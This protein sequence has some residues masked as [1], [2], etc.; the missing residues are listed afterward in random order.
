MKVCKL[1]SEAMSYVYRKNSKLAS[2]AKKL[3]RKKQFRATLAK[4]DLF[5]FFFHNKHANNEICVN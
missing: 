3:R 4:Y 1:Y 2:I 5:A